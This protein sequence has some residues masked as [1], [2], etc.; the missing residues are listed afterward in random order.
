[1]DRESGLLAV[2]GA[3]SDMKTLLASPDPRAALAVEMFCRTARKFIGA[4][5]AVLGGLDA[6]VFTGGIGEH[7][8]A[9]RRRICDGL[10]HL[11]IEIDEARNAAS[12]AV[13]SSGGCAVHVVRADEE[14]AI[15]RHV[16]ALC[17]V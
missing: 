1:V 7:A 14:A 4:L 6:L 17:D 10:G 9:I 13:I 2:S 15:E 5:A 12:G 16:A 8:A 3:T 11:G